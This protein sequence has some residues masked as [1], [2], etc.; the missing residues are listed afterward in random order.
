MPCRNYLLGFCPQGPNCLFTH[1]KV[2]YKFD[3]N[4]LRSWTK[5]VN[6]SKCGKCDEFGHKENFCNEEVVFNDINEYYLKYNN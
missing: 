5:E 1:P 3:F 2:L 4:F 6:L